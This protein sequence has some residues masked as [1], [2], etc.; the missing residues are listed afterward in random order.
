[1]SNKV[2]S[3]KNIAEHNNRLSGKVKL[4]AK[5]KKKKVW[6]LREIS[7]KS[8]H[9]L[10]IRATGGLG[11]ILMHRMIF[12]DFKLINPKIHITFA[13]PPYY[14][15]IVKD[16]PFIDELIDSDTV[17]KE[18]FLVS[19]NTTTICGVTESAKAPFS[20]K[21]RSDIWA[22]HCGITLT[23]H[24]MHIHLSSE[25]IEFGRNKIRQLNPSNKP[26]VIIS[27]ISSIAGKNLDNLQME[28]TVRGLEANGFS[29]VGLHTQSI[30]AFPA[31]VIS[32]LTVRQMMDFVAAADYVISVD[33]A[34]FHMAGGMNKPVIG[35]FSFADGLVYGKYY[36]K[37][38]LV[39]RHRDYT[40]GWTCGPCYNWLNCTKCTDKSIHRK[41]CI[42]EIT[43][44]EIVE[45]T[46]C[47]ASKFPVS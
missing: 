11:D 12:E 17:D 37:F 19:Y 21:N 43:A 13:C 29:V 45:A 7:E 44:N 6:T 16:H 18:D 8:N 28:E 4:F 24:N 3:L 22:E 26:T 32:G 15:D 46:H 47:L 27:P 2:W 42:T 33:T 1:M 31:P 14:H 9:I 25:E 34:T 30:P 35:V 39:Q 10:I 23:H 41:P 40:P 20:Y 36:N 5:P 38:I